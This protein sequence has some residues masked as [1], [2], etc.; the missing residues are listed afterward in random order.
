[1]QIF[2]KQKQENENK[3]Q[4]ETDS[5]QTGDFWLLLFVSVVI[6]LLVFKFYS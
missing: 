3:R 2:K 6:L 5:L 1:M 4:R